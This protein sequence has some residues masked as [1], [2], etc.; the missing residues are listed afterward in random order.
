MNVVWSSCVIIGAIYMLFTNPSMLFSTMIDASSSALS[1]CVK[2]FSIYAV[3]LGL[4]EIVETTHLD[5]Y[6]AKIFR[7]LI[8]LIFGKVDDDTTSAIAT[9]MSTNILGLGNACT[10][11]AIRSISLLDNGSKYCNYAMSCMLFLNTN[12]VQFLPSTIIGLRLLHG[13]ISPYN[14]ILP[15]IIVTSITTIVGLLLLK[16]C[17]KVWVDRL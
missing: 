7:P 1:L 17:S 8:R 6:I 15:T 5:R 13:S 4:L 16:L 14:V 9:N 11:S 2:L 12:F 10:P 3:W